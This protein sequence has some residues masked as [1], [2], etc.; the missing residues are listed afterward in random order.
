MRQH[1]TIKSVFSM[2]F[3][4]GLLC[5]LSGRAYFIIYPLTYCWKTGWLYITFKLIFDL[6][7]RCSGL[8]TKMGYSGAE[9]HW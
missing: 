7:A 6:L 3:L 5:L 2:N 1:K 8:A 4:Y 9:I